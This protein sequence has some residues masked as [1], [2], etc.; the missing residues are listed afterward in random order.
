MEGLKR[1]RDYRARGLPDAAIA[2]LRALIAAQPDFAEAHH[3]LGNGLK[4]LGRFA[5]AI[6]SLREAARLAPGEAAVWLNLGVAALELGGR[7]EAVAAFGRAIALEP[8]AAR[9]SCTTF[10]GTL[11]SLWGGA[12]R[13]RSA[14]RRP[15]ASGRGIRQPMTIWGGCS[16]PRGAPPK[17]S[18]ITARRWRAIPV[19]RPI[20]IWCIRSTLSPDLLPRRFLRSTG[21]GRCGM[22]ARAS[23][24][25]WRAFPATA[26]S[27]DVS[28]ASRRLRIGYVS[29]D[30][31]HHAVS[32]FFEPVLAHHDRSRFEIVCYS[33]APVPDAVT[34]R[35][36]SQ[37]E[38]WRDTARLS[39]AQLAALVRED[40]ID[41]LVD[42]AGHTARHRLLV[43][44]LRPAAVQVSWLGYPNTTGLS[45]MD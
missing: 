31:V 18:P 44:A 11:S 34:L 25:K 12:K 6:L 1:A 30:L 41:V 17:P 16:R 27:S 35:L 21:H 38:L 37:A 29:P 24:R 15:C 32:Y 22:P 43:F 10:S 13:P 9:G 20:A 5:E 36:R 40:G 28:P 7:E 42:L 2:E 39:D 26:L 19:R 14:W 3:Q 23:P 45:A 33:D 4:S 8:A